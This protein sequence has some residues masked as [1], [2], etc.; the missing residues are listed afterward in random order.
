MQGTPIEAVRSGLGQFQR[1][2]ASDPF[3]RDSVRVGV[4]TFGSKA[5]LATGGLV[6]VES[7]GAPELGASGVT[8]LDLA[9]KE[10]QRSM[11]RDVARPIKGGQKGDWRPGVF[12]LTDGRPTDEAG[13]QTDALWQPAREAIVNRRIGQTKPSVIVAV[14]CGPDVDD[15]TL[16]AIST[17]SAF[18]IDPHHYNFVALFQYLS[19][20]ITNSAQ[21][22]GNT[23]DPFADLGASSDADLIRIP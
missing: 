21:P 16:T 8:R 23:D 19:Q 12:I 2:V 6:P 7:F 3:A 20:S 13:N 1:E 14:G 4:I 15:D 9:F 17:G 22:G 11:D 10:L 5:F 18:R